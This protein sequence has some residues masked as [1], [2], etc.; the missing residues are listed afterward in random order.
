MTKAAPTWKQIAVK[1]AAALACGFGISKQGS[2]ALREFR[3]K[4]RR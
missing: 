2:E 4:V 3:R 1:L